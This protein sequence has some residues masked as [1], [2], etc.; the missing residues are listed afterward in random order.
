MERI[1]NMLTVEK[2][3]KEVLDELK[4]DYCEVIDV[5]AESIVEV[6][7]SRYDELVA[8][9]QELML[10]RQALSVVNAYDLGGIRKIFGIEKRG[11]E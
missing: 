8:C 7:L 1:M 2:T 5:K 6:E 9:E 11:E 10:L 3:L 4:E